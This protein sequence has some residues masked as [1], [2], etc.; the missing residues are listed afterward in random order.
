MIGK[1]RCFV[2]RLRGGTHRWVK[3]GS[4]LFPKFDI[5]YCQDCKSNYKPNKP[6][7][8]RIMSKLGYE[9]TCKIVK[10]RGVIIRGCREWT[11]KGKG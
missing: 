1:I 6:I 3:V 5:T 7:I 4:V 11:K 10:H 9:R 2:R 8:E